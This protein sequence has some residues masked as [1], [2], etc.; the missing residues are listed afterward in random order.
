MRAVTFARNGRHHRPGM[1]TVRVAL[2]YMVLAVAT[3]AA[4]MALLM[5][6]ST[7]GDAAAGSCT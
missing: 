7:F 2:V 6:I 4:G 1:V 5:F 3:G